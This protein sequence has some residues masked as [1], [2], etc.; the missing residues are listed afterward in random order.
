M[1]EQHFFYTPEPLCGELPEE[2]TGHA[3]RVLRLK[4]N[5]EMWLMDGAGSFYKARITETDKRRCL[6]E[7]TET[8]PQEKTW[9]GHLHLAVAPTKNIDRI[10]WL[11]EKAVEIGIDEL[12]FLD[13]QYSE[14]HKVKDERIKNIIVA[15]AKQSKKGWMP[16]Y[17]GLM[18]FEDFIM[19]QKQIANGY[20]FICHCYEGKKTL[21]KTA[22]RGGDA[23][24]LIGPEGDFS[25]NEVKQAEECG[26]ISVTLGNKRLRTETA[27]L[28]AAACWQLNNEI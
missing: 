25:M 12:T 14:R 6:Y 22:T 20:L 11:T 28:Y 10:E 16:Q 7:I 8:L 17:N 4:E 13:C 3:V 1:K 26:A 18:S 2:E 21:L 9:N 24:V 27:A 19:K 23:V 15:A 5:D